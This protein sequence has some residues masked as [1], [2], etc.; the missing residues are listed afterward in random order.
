M[1][2][3]LRQL[4]I[5]P[6]WLWLNVVMINNF[7]AVA[8]MFSVLFFFLVYQLLSNIFGNIIFKCF[9]F[10]FFFYISSLLVAELSHAQSTRQWSTM[11]K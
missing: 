11:G 2:R 10:F 6:T 8:R 7:I 4:N 5:F 9:S 1:T 3:K